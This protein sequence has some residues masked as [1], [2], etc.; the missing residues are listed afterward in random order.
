[1]PLPAAT[2]ECAE[3][4][5]P[6]VHV[7]HAHRRR[8]NLRLPPA[9]LRARLHLVRAGAALAQRAAPSGPQAPAPICPLWVLLGHCCAGRLVDGCIKRECIWWE[10]RGAVMS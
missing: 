3:D 2:A 6:A 1:M 9:A 7:N 10:D 5:L 4:P 8:R